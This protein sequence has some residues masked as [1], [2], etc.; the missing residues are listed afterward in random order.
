MTRPAPAVCLVRLTG[1]LDVTTAPLLARSLREHTAG[2]PR[3]L[4]LDL[5]AVRLLAATGV[6]LIVGAQR[7]RDGVHGR[8]HLTGV[9]GNRA[10]ER[11]LGLTGVRPVLDVHDD[12]DALLERLG[13]G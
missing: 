7:N 11:V 8:L 10:V 6:G 1:D 5:S 3:H 9:T 2:R 4:V 12:V 13:R